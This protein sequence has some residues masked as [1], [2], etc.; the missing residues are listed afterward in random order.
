MKNCSIVLESSV[1]SSPTI[2]DYFL[3]AY[4]V[5]V[6]LL[7]I[8]ILIFKCKRQHNMF[9][10]GIITFSYILLFSLL[11]NIQT[12]RII[13]IVTVKSVDVS[14]LFASLS[15]SSLYSG[16]F[17]SWLCISAYLDISACIEVVKQLKKLLIAMALILTAMIYD[18]LRYVF[19]IRDKIEVKRSYLDIIIIFTYKCVFAYGISIYSYRILYKYVHKMFEDIYTKQITMRMNRIFICFSILY[20]GSTTFEFI[21]YIND[22]FSDKNQTAIIILYYTLFEILPSSIFLVATLKKNSSDYSSSM[23]TYLFDTQNLPQTSVGIED[24]EFEEITQ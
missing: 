13:S 24:K 1:D 8:R 6:L 2:R 16:L 3:I 20:I 14:A 4:S 5:L 12:A 15:S 11:C 7:I 18:F 21:F 23:L 22:C 10:E 9:I 17:F 19:E